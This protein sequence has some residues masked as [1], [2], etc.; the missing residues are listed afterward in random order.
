M[1]DSVLHGDFEMGM[2][3][4]NETE[5]DAEKGT[6]KENEA[7]KDVEKGTKKDDDDDKSEKK[8]KKRL[9]LY[10]MFGGNGWIGAQFKEH[11]RSTQ[12]EEGSSSYIKVIDAPLG[13][14][15]DDDAAVLLY[16]EKLVR[17]QR[18]T[19][20]KISE[21]NRDIPVYEFRGVICFVGRTHGPGCPNI[22]YLEQKG[23]LVENVRD[24]L[25]A[26]ATLA[27]T[28]AMLGLH[29][30]YLGTGCIFDSY[31]QQQ[32]KEKEGEK[33]KENAV[34]SFTESD[35]PNYFG[36]SYSVIK[37]F[38]DRLL[39]H[40]MFL[41]SSSKNE[42]KSQTG[43]VL[44]LRIRMPISQLDAPRDF[45]TKIAG[46]KRVIDVPNSVSVLPTLF[47][48]IVRWIE[49]RRVGT[50]NLVNPGAISHVQVLELYKRYVQPAH[51]IRTFSVEE[52]EKQVVSQRSNNVL[53]TALVE[54]EYRYYFNR[55]MPSAAEAI[56]AVLHVRGLLM[57]AKE[58]KKN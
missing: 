34:P 21:L 1:A 26:P 32:Q 48:L 46:Y 3:K 31:Q 52:M 15:A 51:E 16:L 10:V 19:E 8:K 37:G 5:K 57:Q 44:N 17:E 41:S 42:N 47:P 55:P 33:K 39:H 53:D 43:T 58:F 20:L 27:L 38:T 49:D 6:K 29:L 9:L 50:F 40:P 35:P 54:Q 30:V 28:C 18:E 11:L 45:V 14:R 13:V 56:A 4:E 7:E 12:S 23:K 25:Y 2:K 24:N 22:D 36:S